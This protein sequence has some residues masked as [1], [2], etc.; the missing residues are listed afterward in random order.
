MTPTT[1]EIREAAELVLLTR[2]RP[3]YGWELTSFQ[4]CSK[5]L[6]RFALEQTA[7]DGEEGITAEWLVKEY[8]FE[9]EGDGETM[10]RSDWWINPLSG[11][12]G[13]CGALRSICKV[14]TRHQFRQLAA[15]LGIQP[16]RKEQS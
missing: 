2:R 3:E 11:N 9:T 13:I 14:T 4:E 7:E 6:A 12:F 8:L 10:Y 15:A 16:K 5:R 1:K